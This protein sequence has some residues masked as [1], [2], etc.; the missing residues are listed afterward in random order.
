MDNTVLIVEK[1]VRIQNLVNVT[2]K[3]HGYKCITAQRGETAVLLASSHNPDIILIDPELRDMDGIEVIKSIRSWSEVPIIVIS[4]RSEDYDKVMALDSGAD[5]YMT[6]PFSIE[7][8]LARMRVMKRRFP[9]SKTMSA[10][11]SVFENGSLK[12]DYVSRRVT[13]D[14]KEIHLTPIEYQLL[15]ILA[16]NA[17]KVLTHTFITREIWGSSWE[18]NIMS[19]RVFTGTLRRK[20]EP[21]PDSP[22]Y[23]QTHTGIGYMMVKFTDEELQYFK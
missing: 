18:N 20:L 17:G 16:Q 14:G 8:L 12:I 7:E 15:C 10:P 5:D 2:L 3:T 19:L 4:S 23:I 1:D 13:V 22:K 9:S 21:L 11:D 6:K